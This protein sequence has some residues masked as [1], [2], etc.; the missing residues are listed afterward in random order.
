MRL[1]VLLSLLMF[2]GICQAFTFGPTSRLAEPEFLPVAQAFQLSISSAKEGQFVAKWQI[3]DGYYLYQEQFNLSGEHA[4]KLHF[5][6]FPAGEAKE[7]PYYGDVIVYRD[8]F[9]LPI[10]YDINLAPGTQV[11]AI[12]SYQ[13]CA[14]KGLCYAPQT[15]PIQF[16]VPALSAAAEKQRIATLANRSAADADADAYA[17]INSIAPS[18]AQAVSQLISTNNLWTTLTVLFGLGLLLSL[19][20]CVL[21]MVPI[22]SAIVVGTRHSK[23]GGFYYSAVYV[24]AM[25]LTYAAMGGLVGMFGTQLNLQAQLQNPIL[26]AISALLFVLLAL[27]MFGVYEIKLPS[28]WQQRLQIPNN[29]TMP[30][31]QTKSAWQS[32]I[33][34]FIAGILSTLIVSPCVSAP[35]AGVLLYISSQGN[36]WYGAMMLFVMAL[37]M[38]IPLLLVGLFGPKV[39]PK[40]G[41]WLH[42]TKV[43]M[44]FGLLA[45]AIWLLTR[46]LPMSSHLYLWSALALA[47]SGYFIHRAFR[48]A[49]HPIRWFFA[50]AF[51]LIGSIQFI[52]GA[53]GSTNPLQPLKKLSSPSV[54]LEDRVIFDATITN[55]DELKAI[56]ANQDTRPIVLDLYA[57]WC[58]SC[59]VLE[60][61]FVS[62]DVSP[63]L[64]NVQLVRVDVTK[65][66]A[67]NQALMKQF[68]LFGPPS[69]VFL[70][71]QGKERKALTLMGEPT[72][73]ALMDRLGAVIEP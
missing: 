33:S 65:N 72:K 69:L 9:T 70:D 11:N 8:Q 23:L 20:P 30:N 21:P 4:D 58:I 38:G 27:A 2:H 5:S 35:L 29:Q 47:I 12:L 43:F 59:K 63:L 51:F 64:N 39:L 7:D 62:P 44:G 56:V 54:M 57:D 14:D 55:L 67:Q 25:A 61:M 37:G 22:V 40:N 50:L 52:G 45:M 31:T 18:E 26:L 19:T 17:D 16:I 24:L 48:V 34:I 1:L 66:S 6:P 46:W 28:S 10:Y 71:A 49:S 32:T 15:M 68:N 73:S 3:S 42:D 53:T 36:A 60:A 41:E 13:G